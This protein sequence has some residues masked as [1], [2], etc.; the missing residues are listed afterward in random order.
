MTFFRG[1]R[2][3]RHE[4]KLPAEAKGAKALKLWFGGV[5]TKVR[6]WLNGKDLG[7]KEVVAGPHEVDITAAV[8]R[9][10][11]NKLI[12]AVNNT[13]PNEIGTG[14]IIRPVLIYAPK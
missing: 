11:A 6:V 1:V 14:G 13:F 8:D 2:W 4:F 9:T 5:D 10:G 3:C 12:I 7:E